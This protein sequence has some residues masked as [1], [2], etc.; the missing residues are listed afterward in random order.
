[1]VPAAQRAVFY[2]CSGAD[3]TLDGAGNGKGVL[4][5]LRNYGFNAT[6]PATCPATTGG[7]VVVSGVRS[8]RI[9][10]DANQGATQQSGF[11]SIQLELTRG[12]E[13]AS[14]VVGAHVSNVP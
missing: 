10:Y 5:R 9:V 7:D 13:T 11:V 14:L 8:C 12:G 6:A 2:V 1:M 4:Y 3:G